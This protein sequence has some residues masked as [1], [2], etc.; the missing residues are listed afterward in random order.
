MESQHYSA[1][2]GGRRE[3]ASEMQQ[4]AGALR[5]ATSKV[6]KSDQRAAV[7]TL[8][9]ENPPPTADR[10]PHGAARFLE[11]K[12]QTPLNFDRLRD[13]SLLTEQDE[14]Q[15]FPPLR[16]EITYALPIPR[17]TQETEP[18]LWHPR[19]PST[20]A[21]RDTPVG[22]T[23]VGANSLPRQ[24][25]SR[26][27]PSDTR[28]LAG[29]TEQMTDPFVRVEGTSERY[30][31]FPASEEL[32]LSGLWHDPVAFNDAGKG[33]TAL[34][35]KPKKAS[36][37][38]RAPP[39]NVETALQQDPSG[40]PMTAPRKLQL[41][42]HQIKAA[43]R[44]A[45]QYAAEDITVYPGGI[46][47]ESVVDLQEKALFK[48][49]EQLSQD[50]L[51]E[52]LLLEAAARV[53]AKQAKGIPPKAPVEPSP[54]KEGS[55]QQ[56]SAI[57]K[58][59]T[60]DFSDAEQSKSKPGDHAAAEDDDAETLHR[61]LQRLQYLDQ[62]EKEQQAAQEH[63]KSEKDL[64][65]ASLPP[66]AA[67]SEE[68]KSVQELITRCSLKL[69]TF[70]ANK[71]PPS[72]EP[73]PR[74]SAVAPKGMK[75][76]SRLLAAI[77]ATNVRQ[78][79]AKTDALEDELSQPGQEKNAA[80]LLLP[81]ATEAPVA[82][83]FSTG[84]QGLRS[85]RGRAPIP[86]RRSMPKAELVC[87]SRTLLPP[88]PEVGID[89]FISEEEAAENAHIRIDEKVER[90]S[91]EAFHGTP[92][93]LQD[94]VN[95]TPSLEELGQHFL[96]TTGYPHDVKSGNYPATIPAWV[97]RLS[98]TQTSRMAVPPA[99]AALHA[100]PE[101]SEGAPIVESM[102]TDPRSGTPQTTETPLADLSTLEMRNIE[103]LVAGG[104][105]ALKRQAHKVD[106]RHRWEEEKDIT[107]KKQTWKTSAKPFLPARSN[108]PSSI[109][110]VSRRC[111]MGQS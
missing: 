82:L 4:Y 96:P 7:L 88:Q 89:D 105:K 20:I 53:E 31:F 58:K 45:M 27:N 78:K 26:V 11:V 69:K 103:E 38:A 87:V 62:R 15:A 5:R 75:R 72:V 2:F 90:P 94:L 41:S 29:E 76:P 74:N 16:R 12:G 108:A 64:D 86:P 14:A 9:R 61:Q 99:I 95:T 50:A 8:A 66:P 91:Y 6:L 77:E 85:L 93:P 71:G 56:P 73:A 24:L 57:R 111:N 97:S 54:K 79:L 46:S 83:T 49:F 13:L 52:N 110:R 44:A 3:G 80:T 32:P 22:E 81:Q 23:F 10:P 60:F 51:V 59:V 67:A 68:E 17:A 43:P 101:E 48:T 102:P 65:A 70:T 40:L 35:I 63:G 21:E 84:L 47:V 98:Q 25:I 100:L 107:P 34:K 106:Y 104:F 92:T 19:N 39:E 28:L 30:S 37:P 36:V 1:P 109:F 42:E 55:P 18:D 33:Q